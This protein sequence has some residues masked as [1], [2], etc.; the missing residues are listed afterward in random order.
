MAMPERRPYKQEL[1][2]WIRGCYGTGTR[3]SSA[4]DLSKKASHD[5]NAVGRLENDG[6]ATPEKLAALARAVGDNPINILLLSE[7][8]TEDDLVEVPT[9]EG[10]P[11]S[12]EE[13]QL[14]QAFRATRPDMRKFIEGVAQ[15]LA[16][17]GGQSTDSST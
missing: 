15:T 17:E 5:P 2:D 8:L 12:P 3:F 11:L 6:N 7:L 4:H 1:V 10:R 16:A 9:V 14:I 13:Q